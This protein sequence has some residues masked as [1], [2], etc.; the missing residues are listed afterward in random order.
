[1]KIG[2]VTDFYYPWIGGP[3]AAIRNLGRGLVSR[4]HQVDLLAPSADGPFSREDDEGITVTRVPTIPAPVGYNLRVALPPR[5]VSAWL[6]HVSPVVVQVHHPFPLS[7]AAAFMAHR[8]GIPVV[9]TNHT[10]PECSL[11]GLQRLPVAYGAASRAFATWL[12]LVLR[13]ADIVTTPTTTAA[14]MLRAAGF[15]GEIRVISNGLDIE[16][17]QPGP[18]DDGLRR[19]LGLDRRPVVLYTG[20]LD[21]EK[22]MDTW[23]RTAAETS[24]HADVQ[25]AIGGEGTDRSRLESLARDLG[26][27]GRVRF[28]GYVPDHELP[29]LYRLADIY[30]MLAPV[31]LQSIST[32]EAMA[33]GLPVVAAQAGALP[34]LIRPG[35]NGYLVPTSDPAEASAAVLN[36]LTDTSRREM[37]G[38]ASREIASL[39]DLGR[40]ITG[41]EQVFDESRT[42]RG[43]RGVER[44]SA[45]G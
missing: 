20:R 27:G 44:V 18:G 34:E 6:D 24:S 41:Y 3:A 31:E 13:S 43:L 30:L 16:R 19:R 4:G 35:I 40:T 38:K 21:P 33:T 23:L 14:A 45:P 29:A 17:F 11:W 36:L 5:G 26:L 2:I 15:R 8:R 39:H 32:L 25:F 9:A 12:R 7:A 37:M 28:I 22:Q 42:G 10:I 1:M